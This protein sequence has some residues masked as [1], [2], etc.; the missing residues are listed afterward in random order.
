MHALPPFLVLPRCCGYFVIQNLGWTSLGTFCGGLK[1]I[2]VYELNTYSI[3]ALE[4]SVL[5]SGRGG[6]RKK[7]WVVDDLARREE[8]VRDCLAPL[9]AIAG[10]STRIVT[11]HYHVPDAPAWAVVTCLGGRAAYSATGHEELP[12][13]AACNP[14]TTP[15][16]RDAFIDQIKQALFLCGVPVCGPD[17]R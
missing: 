6:G 9:D 14:T 17:G 13:A 12:A 3:E 16:A 11:W 2:H 10:S 5:H 8:G 4:G 15:H 7:T 1:G